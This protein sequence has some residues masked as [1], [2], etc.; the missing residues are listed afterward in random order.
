MNSRFS[1]LLLKWYDKARRDLPWRGEED[2]YKIWLSEVM[3]QQTQV[4]TVIPYYIKWV[5]RFPSIESVALATQDELLK[6]WEGL[7]Y[8]SR[9]RNFHKA[10]K[11]VTARHGGK[12]PAEWETFLSLPGVGGY[13]AAAVLSIAFNQPYFVIDGNVKRVMARLLAFSDI[14]EKGTALFE[15]KLDK[16]LNQDRPGD[17]NEAMMELGSQICRRNEPHCFECPVEYFC[18]AKAEG[19][20][21][22]YPNIPKKKERPHKT[23]VAGIIWSDGKFLIQKRPDEG[24]LGGLWEFPGGKVEN[25]E[26]LDNTLVREIREETGLS[27]EPGKKVGAVDHAYTHFSITLHLYHCKL[28]RSL[29][30]NDALDTHR[31]IQP[32]ERSQFA[33]PGANHKLFHILESQSWRNHE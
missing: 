19:N 21:V 9:C 17:F 31:W 11:I 5:E 28:S 7:G 29:K 26:A 24:L 16:W 2:P 6:F 15:G 22:V 25:G 23:I 12:V 4:D 27:V 10:C 33:F 32:E 20:P 18:K 8:Y 1:S 3:L 30:A 14:V 13:T